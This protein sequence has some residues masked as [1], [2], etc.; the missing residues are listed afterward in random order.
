V[1]WLRLIINLRSSFWFVPSLIV[2]IS[3]GMA[4]AMVEVDSA[5]SDLWLA[6]WPRL[7]GAGADGAR[8]MLSTLAGSMMSIMGITF[9]MTLVALALASGQ[10]TSRILRTFM[11]SRV[12][13]ATLGVFAGVFV[14][15]LIVLKTIRGGDDAGFVP[16]L[17]V[18]FGFVLALVG[19]GVLIYF[20]HHIATSIQATTIVSAIAHE[21]IAAVDHMFPREQGQAADE[22]EAQVLRS[23]EEMP[24][25]TVS[26]EAN[27]YIQS[28]DG[29][30]L[31]R[32][33]QD[34][35]TI[36]RMER[37]IGEFVVRD[38]ALASLALEN[39]ADPEMQA[40]LRACFSIS[41]NRTVDQ[42]PA[43][44]I[45]QIVDIALKALSP[46]SN[47]TSTA[48]ICL[49]YLT[50]I[51]AR[52]ASRE[53]PRLRRYSGDELRVVAIAPSFVGLLTEGLSEIRRSAAGNVAI[54]ASMLHAIGVIGSRTTSQGRRRALRQHVHQIAELADK[55]VGSKHDRAWIERILTKVRDA[56]APEPA[57][58]A[59]RAERRREGA[60]MNG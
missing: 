29:E 27:G 37:G 22:D 21:T 17:A 1:K 5:E 45:R 41:R 32:L 52:L 11:R 15:C 47:D 18:F 43:F 55:T 19:V 57:T 7:F 48:V 30:A 14:Y 35:R 51:L 3:I 36:V 54:M 20:I 9:S 26:A 8:Q 53:F 12:T 31:L 16:G 2:A 58:S 50:A 42:D 25:Q 49:D 6:R 4:I 56:L 59:A 28:V 33:A 24:W 44:G 13:Q 60:P 38:T 10:Y 34:E 46:G 40:A 39:P 23:L